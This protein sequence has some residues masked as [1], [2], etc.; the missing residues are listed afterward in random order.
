LGRTRKAI[1]VERAFSYTAAE[2]IAQRG[3][4]A[5]A[6][7]QWHAT[8][9]PASQ[10]ANPNP[11][12]GTNN[13]YGLDG[14]YS[15]CSDL[16]APGVLPIL[17]YLDSLPF[18]TMANCHRGH[19][20][21]LNNTSPGFRPNGQLDATDIA[22]GTSIPP[23]NVRTIGNALD[24]RSISWTYYGGAY[25]AAVNLANGSTNPLDAVGQAYCSDCNFAALDVAD[26]YA[27]VAAGALPPV[28]F[29][30]PDALVDGHPASSKL[31][32][33]EAMLKKFSIRSMPIPR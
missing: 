18:E 6:G 15:N 17:R 4:H 9:P 5:V 7:T 2:A 25:N 11:K 32:L 27:T 24:E 26:F 16:A 28:S 10:I 1:L 29:V 21:L 20:Y 23:S 19:Y 3:W 14:R 22:N 33:Y 12:P 31:D 8:V 30:K 13:Q